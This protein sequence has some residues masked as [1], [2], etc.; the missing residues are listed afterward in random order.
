MQDVL[1]NPYP[2]D[3]DAI[4]IIWLKTIKQI[5]IRVKTKIFI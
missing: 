5:E 3:M 2:K 1:F 4:K